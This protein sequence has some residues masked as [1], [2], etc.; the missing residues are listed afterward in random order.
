MRD[1]ALF[2]LATDSKLR[3]CVL[4]RLGVVGIVTGGSAR[5]R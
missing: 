5:S 2:N 1:L 3:G 4:V